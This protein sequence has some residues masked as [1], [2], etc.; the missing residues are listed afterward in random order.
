MYNFDPET[1][2]AAKAFETL[3]SLYYVYVH[4]NNPLSAFIF[5]ARRPRPVRARIPAD[6]FCLRGGSFRR[7][8]L[9]FVHS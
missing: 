2:A 4:S 5:S 8:G 9:G 1:Y 3:N 7:A 6:A